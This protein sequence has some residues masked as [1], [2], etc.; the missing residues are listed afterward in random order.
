M[1]PE[2]KFPPPVPLVRGAV[3]C[4]IVGL[5]CLG[6]FLWQDFSAWSVGLGILAGIPLTLTALALYLLAV[7]RELHRHGEL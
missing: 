7:V 3:A 4:M 2:Q 6:V 1:K 5:G